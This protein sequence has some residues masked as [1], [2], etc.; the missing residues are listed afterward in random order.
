MVLVVLNPFK[1]KKKT[2][3]E[4]RDS[5]SLPFNVAHHFQ[6]T[7]NFEWKGFLKGASPDQVF[8]VHEE[9]GR[10]SYGAVYRANHVDGFELAIKEIKI[11][12]LLALDYF[13]LFH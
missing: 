3:V 11:D 7:A 9:L 12:V 1:K 4:R 13:I 2:R 8:V 6:V 10:G 5:F